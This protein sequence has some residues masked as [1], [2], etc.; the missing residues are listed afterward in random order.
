MPVLPSYRNQSIDLLCKSIDWFLY[1]D[2]T[3]IWWVNIKN[4]AEET[5]LGIKFVSKLSFENHNCSLCIKASQK[6]HGLAQIIN[7]MDK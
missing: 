4:S 1:E 7:Y 2:N 3:G 6:F 5:L